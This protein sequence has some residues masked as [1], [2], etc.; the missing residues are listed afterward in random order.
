[1][2]KRIIIL[3]LA[4]ILSGFFIFIKANAQTAIV[5]NVKNAPYNAKGDGVTDDTIAIQTAVN[6]AFVQGGGS[7]GLG[8][9]IFFPE[10]TYIIRSV[11]IKEN[12]IYEGANRDTTIIQ[13]PP[14]SIVGAEPIAITRENPAKLTTASAHGLTDGTVVF[15]SG[16]S[17][18]GWT[19]LN[20]DRDS[21][22]FIVRKIDDRNVF[23]YDLMLMRLS[24]NIEG[25]SKGALT[26]INTLWN[27]G[28]STGE[29]V[30]FFNITQSGWTALNN[31]SYAITKIDDYKFSISFDSS[32]LSSYN[33]ATDPGIHYKNLDLTGFDYNYD[34]SDPGLVRLQEKWLRTFTNGPTYYSSDMDSG[35]LSMKNLTF[36]GNSANWG[37]YQNWEQEQAALIFLSADKLKN[38]RLKAKIENC[39]FRNGIADAINV[40]HSV[41][42][43]VANVV[44]EDVFRGGFVSTGDNDA[45]NRIRIKNLTTK[46]KI[47]PTGIDFEGYGD[48]SGTKPS[49]IYMEDVNIEDGDFD[50]GVEAGYKVTGKNIIAKAPVLLWGGDATFN[51][52]NSTFYFNSSSRIFRPGNMTF[53]NCNF[54]AT[55]NEPEEKDR[56]IGIYVHWYNGVNQSLTFNDCNFSVDNSV[57]ASDNTYAIHSTLSKL[58]DGNRIFLNKSKIDDA[59]DTGFNTDQRGAKWSITE[60]Y[61]GAKT[62][63]R[64]IGY[65]DQTYG[66]NFFNI[67]LDGVSFKQGFGNIL[68]YSTVTNN[69]LENK[70]IQ[71][72]ESANLIYSRYGLDGNNYTGSR[73]ILGTNPP[74]SETNCLK[75]DIYRLKNPVSNQIHEWKCMDNGY[76]SVN[77]SS[78]VTGK[79]LAVWEPQAVVQVIAVLD[80]LPASLSS[81]QSASIVV[82]GAGVTHYKYLLDS[83]SW[84]S[85]APIASRITLSGLGDGKH[86]LRVIGKNASGVWQI[87]ERPTTFFW[88][89]LDGQPPSSTKLRSDLNGDGSVNVL[90]FGILAKD[91]LKNL[92]GS[93]GA[94][95]DIDQDGIVT[96]LDAGIMMS[97]WEK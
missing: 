30:S 69:T 74:T 65:Y 87:V 58:E 9:K 96:V 62:P 31:K 50:L 76:L 36:D 13:R 53:D 68:G 57:E 64:A 11:S 23:L 90:D 28:L 46:G 81:S 27:H 79:N 95:S 5:L 6:D 85:E 88:L 4:V 44:A 37:P 45:N 25:M 56:T 91:F 86:T 20:G 61:I 94:N 97:E 19:S 39:N 54:I 47:D 15:F 48:T 16:I 92:T 63:I 43:D 33:A 83:G 52:S 51:F 84:S 14:A 29:K 93:A 40:H 77:E 73:L 82:L 12:I 3:L 60:S 34:S 55:E 80:N 72:D 26:V 89:V 22:A 32:A 49:E 2:N 66:N 8:A 21:G 70:N 59:F 41:D 1:M 67:L 7:T 71:I 75:N 42:I 38:G 35:L 24:A 78:V 10:G 18:S 17:Q